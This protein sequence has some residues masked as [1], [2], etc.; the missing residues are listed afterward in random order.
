MIPLLFQTS[1]GNLRI[2]T[3]E[4]GTL[5]LA[6]FT[7]DSAVMAADSAV[8]NG[9]IVT[10]TNARKILQVGTFGA[11]AICGSSRMD[12]HSGEINFY[13]LMTRLRRQ[14]T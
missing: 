1:G 8:S 11:A 5:V 3:L 4:S 2:V 7:K 10:R 9:G 12:T 6:A 13:E 14:M